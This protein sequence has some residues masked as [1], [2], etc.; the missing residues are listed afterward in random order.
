MTC[1]ITA[2]IV[3]LTEG[4]TRY[5]DDAKSDHRGGR[6]IGDSHNASV[7]SHRQLRYG[8]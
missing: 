8:D 4:F 2:D 5:V 7:E 1:S 6:Q 3:A